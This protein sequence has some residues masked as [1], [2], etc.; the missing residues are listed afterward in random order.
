[1]NGGASA[2][3]GKSKRDKKASRGNRPPAVYGLEKL[4]EVALSFI[5]ISNNLHGTYGVQQQ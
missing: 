4:V 2:S 1:V 5:Y 3:T